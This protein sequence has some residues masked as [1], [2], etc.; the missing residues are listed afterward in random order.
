MA[1][2][3]KKICWQSAIDKFLSVVLGAV[4][5]IGAS[6]FTTQF[7]TSSQLHLQK[8]Q[9]QRRVF[10][11]L[12][13]R[14]LTTEQLYVSRYEAL[15][16]SDYSEEL[17]RRAGKPKDSLDLQETQRWMHRSEDL[18]FEIVKNDQALFEDLATVRA[19]F[20]DTPRLRELCDRI[21]GIHSMATTAPPQEG[22]TEKLDQWKLE[23]DRQLQ[24]L[25][26]DE[27]GMPIDELVAFLLP[28]LPTD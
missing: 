26:T 17:W 22:S 28:Q 8:V 2:D 11:R 7:Q 4:L 21:Y 18:V 1:D 27:Y 23:A 14:K 13:G 15:I 9:E 25:V 6:Y 10:A 16:F 20:P 24:K 5:A 19:L 3:A 12:M